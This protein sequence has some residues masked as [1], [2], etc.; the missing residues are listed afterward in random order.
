MPPRL[1]QS[2]Q[3]KTRLQTLLEERNLAALDKWLRVA[4]TS[5]LP[6][7][8][9]VARNVCQDDDA[10]RAALITPWSTGPCAGQ[11]CRIKRLKRPGYGRAKLDLLG[12][13]ILRR[14]IGPF[15]RARIDTHVRELSAA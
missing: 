7:F 3:L 11:I 5:E 12:Q 9:S 1:P 14:I 8:Q 6:A 10:V 4:E 2:Y 13:R 15:H